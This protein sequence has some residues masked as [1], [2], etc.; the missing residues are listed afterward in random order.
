MLS[1]TCAWLVRTR[2]VSKPS[3]SKSRVA[4][5]ARCWK[6]KLP[7]RQDRGDV[8]GPEQIVE[9]QDR[10]VVVLLVDLRHPRIVVLVFQH[11]QA[12]PPSRRHTAIS[13]IPCAA[14]TSIRRGCG[15]H[16]SSMR[17]RKEPAT[18]SAHRN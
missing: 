9:V 11:R 10:F 18:I 8:I 6:L 2:R 15:S 1:V 17:R 14:R 12:P 3:D 13:T 4:E 16:G 5:H 7:K